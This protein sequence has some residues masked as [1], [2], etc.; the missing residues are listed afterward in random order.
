MK[1]LF[2]C[3]VVMFG[4]FI[5]LGKFNTIF[6]A[7]NG[8]YVDFNGG[9][10]KTEGIAGS[11]SSL[12]FDAWINPS[13]V[14]GIRNVIS[15]GDKTSQGWHYIFGINGGS[16]SLQYRFGSGSSKYISAGLISPNMWTHITG[17]I[18]QI[19][20]TLYINGIKTITSSGAKNL[21]SLGSSIVVG[22][23][24]VGSMDE[25]SLSS[26][27][28]LFDWNLDGSRG[29]TSVFDSSGNGRTGTLIGGDYQI[30]FHGVV[31]TPTPYSSIPF[32]SSGLVRPTWIFPTVGISGGI[33]RPTRP[34]R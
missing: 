31:P 4:V 7:P 17:K 34:I 32:P 6:A 1:K 12:L 22:D 3:F 2:S 16:L 10:I 23:A 30:H 28:N 21:S 13:N 15:I 5:V 8:N 33:I 25:V 20:T 26:G 18:S 27:S 11:F 14:S 9:Y 29:Q 24:F 19:E